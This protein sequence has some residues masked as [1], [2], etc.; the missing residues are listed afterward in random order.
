[1]KTKIKL[2]FLVL[3]F[4]FLADAQIQEINIKSKRNE[5]KSVTFSYEKDPPGS[6]FLILKFDPLVNAFDKEFSRTIFTNKGELLTLEPIDPNVGISYSFRYWYIMGKY[7]PN[8]DSMFVYLL[9]L[10]TQKKCNSGHLANI[11]ELYYNGEKPKNWTAFLFEAEIGDTVY[12]ARKGQVVKLVDGIDYDTLHMVS[13]Q[14][15]VNELVIEH[16]DGT[17][18][19]YSGFKKNS[20]T[21]KL[22]QTVFPRTPLGIIDQYDKRK[23]GQLRFCVNYLWDITWD[24]DKVETLG[25][26]INR[27]AYLN[28]YFLTETGSQQLEPGNF[29]TVKISDEIITKEFTRQ[30]LKKW[31]VNKE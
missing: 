21:V 31:N 2:L 24:K 14:S 15:K 10:S 27:Y 1:M 5:D 25:C 30:E 11:D 6:Y 8:F 26:K 12:A 18:A 28:P 4:P 19:T 23:K 13:C 29:Y 17:L 9:P 20:F 16:K 22:G 3:L 7:K